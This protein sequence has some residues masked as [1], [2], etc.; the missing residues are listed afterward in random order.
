MDRTKIDTGD[1][2]TLYPPDHPIGDARFTRMLERLVD[3]P[4]LLMVVLLGIPLLLY[5]I[6]TSP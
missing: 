1:R 3:I 2:P 4:L 5:C 6:L